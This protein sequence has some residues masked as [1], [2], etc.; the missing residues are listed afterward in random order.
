[1]RGRRDVRRLSHT[2]RG[3][4]RPRNAHQ[5]RDPTTIDPSTE[6]TCELHQLTPDQRCDKQNAAQGWCYI[7]DGSAKMCP[8][9]L[10]FSPDALKLGV[11]TNLECLEAS[12]GEGLQ[13]R[14]RAAAVQRRVSMLGAFSVDGRSDDRQRR[15]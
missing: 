15:R 10:L 9:A 5:S 14:T 12:T 4:E 6:L 13:T 11:Q 1:V 3:G 8:Q 7:D 2:S